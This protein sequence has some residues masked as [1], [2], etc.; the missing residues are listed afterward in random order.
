MLKLVSEGFSI[1]KSATANEDAF[2][3]STRSFGIADGVSGW[4]DF[5]FSS[6]AYSN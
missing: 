1:G 5:G 4:N 6:A 2:F 3:V